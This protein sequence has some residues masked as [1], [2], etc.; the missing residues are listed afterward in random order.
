MD[1]A[2]SGWT[3]RRPAENIY[4]FYAGRPKHGFPDDVP[5]TWVETGGLSLGVASY[6]I[7]DGDEALVYDCQTSLEHARAARTEL[8]A[9]GVTR[10]TILLSHWHLD[11]VAGTEVFSDCEVLAG[12]LTNEF[13]T[14]HRE[15]IE[16][17]NIEGPPGIKPLILPTRVLSSRTTLQIGAITV[18][19]FPADIHSQ[20]Q[21][22]LW[23][24]ESRILLAADAVE[25]TVTYLAEPD[26]LET[27]L[28]GLRELG[29]V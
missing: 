15:A 29:R 24:P 17:G 25:D 2:T 8:E 28:V 20:D 11:H 23:L 5:M 22:L 19:A 16:N 3:V 27:H 9:A 10:F 1:L 21:Y 12:E 13:L 26:R 18:E 4:A 7:V 14:T 6:A